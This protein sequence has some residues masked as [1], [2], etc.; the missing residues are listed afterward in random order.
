ML[1]VHGAETHPSPLRFDFP[2]HLAFPWVML[3][4][5]DHTS[6]PRYCL[7][8]WLPYFLSTYV[9]LGAADRRRGRPSKKKDARGAG[10]R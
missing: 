4:R 6:A 8:F 7:M 3:K 2:F 10:T 5:R 9:Q 1:H